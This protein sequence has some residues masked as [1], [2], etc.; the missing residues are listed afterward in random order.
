[1]NRVSHR[2][3]AGLGLLALLATALAGCAATNGTAQS[4][5]AAHPRAVDGPAP[6]D[7]TVCSGGYASRFPERQA[8]GRV[9]REALSFR[10]IY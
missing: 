2:S 10:D 4:A 8:T 3:T 1:M 7:Y 9:C 5:A 6:G